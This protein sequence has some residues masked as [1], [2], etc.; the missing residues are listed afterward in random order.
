VDHICKIYFQTHQSMKICMFLVEADNESS[1]EEACRMVEKLLVPLEEGSNA[2]KQAQLK[3][4]A[5][6]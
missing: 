3:E 1:L 2:H 5:G 6:N 4:L